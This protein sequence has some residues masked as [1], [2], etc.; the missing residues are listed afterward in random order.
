MKWST[1]ARRRV[2]RDARRRL[3]VAPLI[4][5]AMTMSFDAQFAAEPAILPGDVDRAVTVDLRGRQRARAEAPCDGVDRDRGATFETC[6]HVAPPSSTAKAE[7][8]PSRL[9]KGTTTRPL[10]CTTG[11][12]PRP[13]GRPAGTIGI[14]HVRPPSVDV[15]IELQVARAEVVELRV[16]VAVERAR[17]RV[18][19][20]GPVLVE[21]DGLRHR[22]RQD[23]GWLQL[24]PLSR[25]RLTTTFGTR[26]VRGQSG[27]TRQARRRGARRTPRWGR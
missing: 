6:C 13:F 22:V 4:D 26:R 1:A 24:R 27:A 9:S 3:Q 25:D 15:L 14:D 23:T 5:F 21:I 7:M 19:A 10:G 20:D 12:P 18:V 11:C 2:D 17:G 16:A 8:L